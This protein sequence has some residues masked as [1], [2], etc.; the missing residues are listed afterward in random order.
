LPEV[1][2]AEPKRER[3]PRPLCGGELQFGAFIEQLSKKLASIKP[4]YILAIKN[5]RKESADRA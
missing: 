1:S 3:I 5:N 2:L 4:E